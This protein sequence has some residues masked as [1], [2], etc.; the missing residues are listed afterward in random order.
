MVQLNDWMRSIDFQAMR[1]FVEAHGEKVRY[2]KGD[3]FS[4][5]GKVSLYGGFVMSGYFKYCVISPK[6]ENAVTGFSF[7][8]ECVMDY[9]RSFLQNRPSMMSIIAGRDSE[10][11]QMPISELR[12]HIIAN[13]P[14]II[15]TISETVMAEAYGRY[16]NLYR[17]SPTDR[18]IE[19]TRQYPGLTDIVILRD[20]ASYLQIDP[21]YLSRIRKKLL[22]TAK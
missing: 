17:K 10:V 8:E 16:L 18:Y 12:E 1:E 7:P 19:L 15:R 5:E 4:V 14:G 21:V 11:V 13:N 2:K 22:Q 6:G 9:T 20:I 3:Y